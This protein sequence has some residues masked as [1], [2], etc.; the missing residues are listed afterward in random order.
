MILQTALLY[1]LVSCTNNTD[2]AK[3]DNA[4][5]KPS[6]PM[7]CYR[8]S[9]AKD[10]ITLKLIHVGESITGTLAYKMPQVNTAKGTIQGYIENDLLVATFTPFVDSTMPKQI[11]FK[12]VG[13]YFI[14][15]AGETSEE[16]G[17]R[18]FKNRN[19]LH[20]I[21]AIKLV[22]FDCK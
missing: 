1:L 8:Y 6:S 18:F 15:G 19:E 2:N 13:N 3:P 4:G 21:D 10:T 16:N 5:S 7:N 17:K 11:A 12:L 14:E 20:F 9:N 22:E